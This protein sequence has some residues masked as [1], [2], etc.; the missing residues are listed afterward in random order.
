MNETDTKANRFSLKTSTKSMTLIKAMK[1]NGTKT[2]R[3]AFPV[4]QRLTAGLLALVL[5]AGALLPAYQAQAV[6]YWKL[7]WAGVTGVA[8]LIGGVW[9]VTEVIN[10]PGDISGQVN[11]RPSLGD[12][13][14]TI[15]AAN[16]Y[17]GG[18]SGA[19]PHGYTTT[20]GDY[21]YYEFTFTFVSWDPEE[22][23]YVQGEQHRASGDSF[24]SQSDFES[25]ITAP[26]ETGWWSREFT[27]PGAWIVT[28]RSRRYD[29]GSHPVHSN[30]SGG[31]F[32]SADGELASA[33]ST[34]NYTYEARLHYERKK[35]EWDGV[36]HRWK[37]KAWPGVV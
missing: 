33:A 26:S 15:E 34:L 28:G 17:D 22:E 20:R 30:I 5:A 4:K 7:I 35:M 16:V 11:A 13:N 32:S 27:G 9:T 37:N 31:G 23:E 12:P 36:N 1:R 10:G 14:A 18:V 21:E 2:G 25:R 6:G 3:S 19:G 29:C 8:S 24:M